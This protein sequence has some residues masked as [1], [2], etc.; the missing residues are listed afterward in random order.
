MFLPRGVSALRESVTEDDKGV[1]LE[2]DTRYRVEKVRVTGW[3]SS[4]ATCSSS[5]STDEFCL[6]EILALPMSPD[7]HMIHTVT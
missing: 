1:A 4:M 3:L 7:H 5:L 6:S 2:N